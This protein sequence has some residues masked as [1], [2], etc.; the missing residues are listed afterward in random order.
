MVTIAAAGLLLRWLRLSLLRCTKHCVTHLLDDRPTP[1]AL[2]RRVR[3]LLCR[4]LRL[5]RRRSSSGRL[6]LVLQQ[7]LLG[8]NLL[9][10][11]VALRVLVALLLGAREAAKEAADAL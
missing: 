5:L 10:P 9:G 8:L 1:A 11:R 7:R 4:L 3:L 2:W 6:G